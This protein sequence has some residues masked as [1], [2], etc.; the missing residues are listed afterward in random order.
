VLEQGTIGTDEPAVI[1]SEAD[2]VAFHEKRYGT[3]PED[4]GMMF[5]H[6]VGVKPAPRAGSTLAGERS[7]PS[8]GI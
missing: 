5:V 4:T 1:Q 8:D 7:S 6:L 2:A 3:I